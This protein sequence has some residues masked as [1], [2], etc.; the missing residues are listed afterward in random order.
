VEIFRR[1]VS[2]QAPHSFHT[3]FHS[4]YTQHLVVDTGFPAYILCLGWGNVVRRGLD[5]EQEVKISFARL[6]FLGLTLGLSTLAALG[7]SPL[8]VAHAGWGVYA[9]QPKSLQFRPWSRA[10]QR[11]AAR[12]R[13]QQFRYSRRAVSTEGSRR[14]SA[15][16]PTGR[17]QAPLF[18]H[19]RGTARKAVPVAKGQNPGVRFRPERRQPM[20]GQPDTSNADPDQARLQSQFR[21]AQTGR[22]ATYEELQYASVSRQRPP[23]GGMPYATAPPQARYGYA[24]GW[25]AW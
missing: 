2:P 3:V 20:Y 4:F 11:Q 7:F 17:M 15:A 12:W 6:S 9:N 14:P 18:S 19:G 16:L 23:S 8:S 5:G 25:P 22:R 10:E 24:G 1:P 21:P 13:P